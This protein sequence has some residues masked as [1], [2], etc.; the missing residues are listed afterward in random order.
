MPY[1][2]GRRLPVDTR[3]VRRI[4]EDPDM[5][6]E[7]GPNFMASWGGPEMY[8]MMSRLPVTARVTYYAIHEGAT[9]E[10]DVANITGLTP[11][12]VRSG[13]K[14]LADEGI[15]PEGTVVR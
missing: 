12:E 1:E 13:L 3:I 15:V 8:R 14:R 7:Q 9:T 10:S 11:T 2:Y 6:S 5:S 4:Q